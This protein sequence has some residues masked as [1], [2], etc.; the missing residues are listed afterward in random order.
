MRGRFIFT[1]KPT[2]RQRI[3]TAAKILFRGNLKEP[4]PWL[5]SLL[6]APTSAAGVDVIPETAVTLAVV[7]DCVNILAQTIG[8]L[9]LVI[10]KL[11]PNQTKEK[12]KTHPLWNVLH[13]APN[14]EMTSYTWKMT[15]MSHL[16]LW[17][18]HYSQIIRDQLGRPLALWPLH[19][20]R[21]RVMRDVKGEDKPIYYLVSP[22]FGEAGMTTLA[23]EDMLHIKGLSMTGLVGLSPIGA[24]REAIGL[25]L[26]EQE[27]GA[28]IFSNDT[29]VGLVLEHPGQLSDKAYD[30]LR[31]SMEEQSRQL[32]DKHR[33]QILEEGLKANRIGLPPEDAQFL[34]S[35]EFNVRDIA[36]YYRMP[37]YKLSENLSSKNAN[38]EQLAIE[39]ITDTIMPWCVNIEQEIMF[40]LFSATE[41]QAFFAEFH[42]DS[43]L[44]GDTKTRYEAYAVGRQWGWLSA[45][46]VRH[47]EHMNPIDGG[48]RYMVPVNMM[49]AA[50]FGKVPPPP[51]DT[52]AA[53]TA[54][55]NLLLAMA[56]QGEHANGKESGI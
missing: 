22:M 52:P 23:A 17:G 20:Q 21:V 40:K 2:L 41:R 32:K 1:L 6:G 24:A 37:L 33:M 9:P 18:N 48:D 35:R 44:R 50:Q 10:Y 53:R 38:V 46:E 16:G 14:D 30:R 49:D 47:Q 28:R 19:P 34:N 12:A 51:T 55:R 45:N 4:P 13:D 3:A 39:F 7:W 43:L 26:A 25:G 54:V 11:G 56:H 5:L 8:T 29:T 36:R 31:R 42:I 15:V 27:F